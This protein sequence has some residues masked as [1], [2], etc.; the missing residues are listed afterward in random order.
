MRSSMDAQSCASVPPEPA[1]MSTKQLFGSS[2]VGEH[3]AELQVCDERLD[4]PDVCG[5]ALQAVVVVLGL[6]H[7]EQLAGIGDVLPDPAE[8]EHHAFQHFALASQI[9]RA[10]GVAPDGGVFGELR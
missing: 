3:A 7:F 9:L 6:R 8:A 10:L 2:R 5:D 1:W 4:V